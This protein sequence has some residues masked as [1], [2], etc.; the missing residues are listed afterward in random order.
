MPR[1]ARKLGAENLAPRGGAGIG[2]PI[3]LVRKERGGGRARDGVTASRHLDL[4]R[5]N[6][7]S[8]RPANRADGLGARA[9]HVKECAGRAARYKRLSL[10]LLDVR[11][12][13]VRGR[14]VL[15]A[16]ARAGAI[17]NTVCTT[18]NLMARTG[19]ALGLER[20][21]NLGGY[22]AHDRTRRVIRIDQP[23]R[24]NTLG[25]EPR[26]HTRLASGIRTWGTRLML[27]R[28]LGGACP[29]RACEPGAETRAREAPMLLAAFDPFGTLFD[30]GGSR[31]G[32]GLGVS[33]PVVSTKTKRKRLIVLSTKD[34][35]TRHPHGR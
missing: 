30:F 24:A 25:Y 6:L 14:I 7:A 34:H 17:D 16:P 4:S 21:E 11:A 28:P 1:W 18:A 31:H 20:G 2:L 8:A 19:A 35:V 15:K 33:F 29:P 3:R 23:D 10:P 9:K 13:A 22:L 26:A 5:G 12:R 27:E 32:V